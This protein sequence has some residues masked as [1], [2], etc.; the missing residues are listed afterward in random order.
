MDL[1]DI[2]T[3]RKLSGGGGGGS[4]DL[5]TAQVT[6]RGDSQRWLGLFGAVADISEKLSAEEPVISID[7]LDTSV[8]GD[9]YTVVLYQ[10]KTY[11]YTDAP[12]E[13]I[14]VSGDVSLVASEIGTNFTITGD[15]TITIS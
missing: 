5:S 3:A 12:I 11:G 4:S 6:V 15:C 13:A 10:G 8:A 2:V 7:T 9:T 1:F 14:A